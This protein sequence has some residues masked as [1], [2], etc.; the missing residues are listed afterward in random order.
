MNCSILSPFISKAMIFSFLY[1]KLQREMR[2]SAWILSVRIT[3]LR[4]VSIGVLE[5]SLL[6]IKTSIERLT[7]FFHMKYRDR[8]CDVSIECLL[9]IEWC[10]DAIEKKTHFLRE[11]RKK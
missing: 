6:D 8:F 11:K 9:G 1:G 4:C 3:R 10:P 2:S 7:D 5:E